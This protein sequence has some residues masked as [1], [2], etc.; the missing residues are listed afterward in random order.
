MQGGI[1]RPSPEKEQTIMSNETLEFLNSHVLIGYTEK[2]GTA[3]WYKRDLD[4]DEPNHY[5]GA[6]P[7][8][9]IRRRLFDWTIVDGELS[10]TM[11]TLDGVATVPV[12]SFKALLRSDT[13]AVLGVHSGK[14]QAHQFSDWLV[15]NV[16]VLL[17]A[18]LQIGSAGLLKGGAQAWVQIEMEDT[19]EA[20]GKGAEPVKFRPFLTA[21]TSVDGS[22]AT[23]YLTG[24]QVVV[25]DNTLSAAVGSSHNKIKIRHTS[26]SL[27]RMDE[28]REGLGIIEVVAANFQ[29]EVE[30]LTAEY[31]SDDRFKAFVET[32]TNPGSNPSD[33]SK[34]MAQKK[35]SELTQ[36]WRFDNRVAPWKNSAY[37][38]LAAANT[39]AHHLQTVRN[40]S[41]AERN[42]ATAIT[43]GFDK[44]DSETLKVLATV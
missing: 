13:L 37:G 14:Y 2:R 22:L 30:A 4:A 34:N 16:E 43:G 40:V 5:I 26:K 38:V 8:E 20:V 24:N 21:A 11:I 44:L 12:P 35:A 32:V 36:L 41:R 33:R 29:A 15:E 28:A 23:T 25:C 17:G 1:R 7:I 31:V 27:S 3:W 42:A 18:Q 19:F 10:A 39:H 9:D 6:I